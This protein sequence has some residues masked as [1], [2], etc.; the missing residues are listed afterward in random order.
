LAALILGLTIAWTASIRARRPGAFRQA[1]EPT[2]ELPDIT[3]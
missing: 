2:L 1:T 3:S